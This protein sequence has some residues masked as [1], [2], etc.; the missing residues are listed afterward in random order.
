MLLS[1]P[2]AAA[3]IAPGPPTKIDFE[4]AQVR[5]IHRVTG[6]GDNGMVHCNRFR[7]Y[8]KYRTEDP[9]VYRVTYREYR[10]RGLWPKLTAVLKRD[11]DNWIW[12]KGD[13]PKC[14]ITVF[15]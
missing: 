4:F 11:G 14:A 6:V 13:P 3:E 15:E 9:Y 1:P 7:S 12:V 5:Q 8:R 2:P 10:A